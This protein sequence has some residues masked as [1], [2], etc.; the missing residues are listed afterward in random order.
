[1]IETKVFIAEKEA[2][3]YFS[4]ILV[5]QRLDVEGVLT[6]SKEPTQNDFDHLDVSMFGQE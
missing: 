1:M 2:K 3:G 5:V 4:P 6:A